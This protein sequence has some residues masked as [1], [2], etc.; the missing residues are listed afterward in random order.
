MNFN[1]IL[2]CLFYPYNYLGDY[3]NNRIYNRVVNE[4]EVIIL[5]DKTVREVSGIFGVSKSTVHKD[6]K[7]RLYLVDKNLY[8]KVSSI[9]KKHAEIKHIRGGES[10]KRKFLERKV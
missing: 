6:M 7:D 8:R 4:A 5:G 1:I 9:M 3:M 2:F 10:T